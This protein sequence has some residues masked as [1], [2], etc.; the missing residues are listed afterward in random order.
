MKDEF[1]TPLCH[2]GIHDF[3]HCV[4]NTFSKHRRRC[5]QCFPIANASLQQTSSPIFHAIQLRVI[6]PPQVN[7]LGA[8]SNA[9]FAWLLVQ[10]VSDIRQV[11]LETNVKSERSRD[12][13]IATLMDLRHLKN[14]KWSQS[15]KHTEA[16]SCSK[17]RL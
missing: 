5:A 3:C 2:L 11:S 13:S 10:G 9:N 4:T 7:G 15:S 6:K 14:S 12:S 16:G 1:S 17:L 8:F